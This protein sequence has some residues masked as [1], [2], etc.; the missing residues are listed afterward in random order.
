M[1]RIDVRDLVLDINGKSRITDNL[2][3][4]LKN[5]LIGQVIKVIP[6]RNQWILE[7]SSILKL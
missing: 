2:V 5:K 1:G 4:N 6:R 7:D 3:E